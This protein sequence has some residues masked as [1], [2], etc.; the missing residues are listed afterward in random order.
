MLEELINIKNLNFSYEKT[1][2]LKN[3]SFSVYKGEFFGIIGP[4]GGGKTT[5]IKLILNLL[6]HKKGQIKIFSQDPK[7][8]L[9]N[10][11]GYV[12]QEKNYNKGFPI[13]VLDVVL[14][15]RLSK[16]KLISRYN[17]RDREL[18]HNALCSVGVEKLYKKQMQNLSGGQKQRVAIARALVSEPDMLILDEPST[19]ID[20]KSHHQL[21]EL[22]DELNQ[23]MTVIMI[24]HDLGCMMKR[25]DSVA[26][27]NK[28][29]VVKRGKE[30]ENK[31]I[32][33]FYHSF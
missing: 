4:N 33:E 19:G 27:V 14:M 16:K 2:V 13:S 7:N 6:P 1:T 20:P 22:L 24:S 12:P 9:A 23:K 21:Y 11:I 30:L 17:K 15:G 25:A 31:N 10:R 26:Y 3:V 18:A 32:Y 5:L 8:V 28:S 29:V